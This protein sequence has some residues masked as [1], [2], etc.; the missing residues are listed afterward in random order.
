MGE[1]L[2]ILAAALVNTQDF[3][4]EQ[5]KDTTLEVYDIAK[6]DGVAEVYEVIV[7][8]KAK[9][10]LEKAIPE[11]LEVIKKGRK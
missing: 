4:K 8:D 7:K 1:T 9:S 3:N 11:A 10:K 2:A 5:A 6:L